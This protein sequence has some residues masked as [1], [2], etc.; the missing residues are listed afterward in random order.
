MPVPKRA[1]RRPKHQQ[2]KTTKGWPRLTVR[3]RRAIFEACGPDAFLDPARLKYP[4]MGR[5]C[6][7]DCRG[8]RVAKQRAAQHNPD[9]M[10]RADAAGRAAH[11][12]WAR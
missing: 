7:L 12:R 5:D 11:C 8:V 4:V 2:A 3:E 6:R 10:R 9:L 1:L